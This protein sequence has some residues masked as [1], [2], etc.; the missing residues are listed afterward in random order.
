M[1]HWAGESVD[2][3]KKVQP[4]GEIVGELVDEAEQLLR[5]WN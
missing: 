1:P 5:R 4:A 2:G 3:V